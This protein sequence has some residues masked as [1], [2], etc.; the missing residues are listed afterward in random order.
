MEK[1]KQSIYDKSCVIDNTKFKYNYDQNNDCFFKQ[2]IITESDEY[3]KLNSEKLSL[4]LKIENDAN[5]KGIF[6]NRHVDKKLSDPSYSIANTDTRDKS[7]CKYGNSIGF[8]KILRNLSSK[9]NDKEEITKTIINNNCKEGIDFRLSNSSRNNKISL[10]NNIKQN[11]KNNNIKAIFKFVNVN[12]SNNSEDIHDES[13][14]KCKNDNI[15]IS[16]DNNEIDE[17]YNT[18]KLKISSISF[19]KEDSCFLNLYN[20]FNNDINNIK[21]DILTTSNI[22]NS[23]IHK[24]TSSND[25]NLKLVNYNSNNSKQVRFKEMK[26]DN[27]NTEVRDILYKISIINKTGKNSIDKFDLNNFSDCGKREF[28]ENLIPNKTNDND[29]FI[30]YC[31]ESYISK[32]TNII[33]TDYDLNQVSVIQTNITLLF[34]LIRK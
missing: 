5:D 10:S 32:K 3:F 9:D 14:V 20:P 25:N 11:N 19:A 23:K 22:I 12:K 34:L 28:I 1:I 6:H 18:S 27:T 7:I 31:N 21:N 13:Y 4:K 29:S 30:N 26:I 33:L 16:F 15:R 8:I 17:N 2:Q 24:K